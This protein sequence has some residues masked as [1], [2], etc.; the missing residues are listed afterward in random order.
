[1]VRVHVRVLIY[2][3]DGQQHVCLPFKEERAGAAPVGGTISLCIPKQ[4][5]IPEKDVM[6]WCKTNHG[7]HPSLMAIADRVFSKSTV[8]GAL[9]G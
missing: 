2:A 8:P 5:S 6:C 4:R 3:A 7:D 1:M 9:P